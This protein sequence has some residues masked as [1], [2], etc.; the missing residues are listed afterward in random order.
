MEKKSDFLIIIPAYNEEDN[1]KEVVERAGKYGDVCIVNDCSTDSTQEILNRIGGIKVISHEKNTHI[2]G[3]VLDGMR[4][5]VDKGYLYAITIDAGLSHDP[6]DIPLFADHGTSDLVIGSR[7]EKLNT[8]VNRR[9]LSLIGN[10]IYNISL[11]FPRSL[12]KKKI[13]KDIP[14]GFRRYS[15]R[16]MEL[17]LT[18]K[19]QSRSFDFLFESVM[20]IYRKGFTISAVPITYNFTG[21]SLNRRVLRDCLAIC[22]KSIA[23]LN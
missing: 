9:L 16:A 12:F 18:E 1:I 14:S 13:Y 7:V 2:A 23:R 21:S 6:D 3:A 5:A 17:L 22:L 11:D 10:V 4:Y 8:P 15:K 19:M 20:H